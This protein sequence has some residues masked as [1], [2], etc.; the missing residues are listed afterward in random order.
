[1][2]YCANMYA[3]VVV[4]FIFLGKRCQEWISVVLCFSL[5]AF[6]FIH[7]LANFHLG[8]L[9]F[10]LLSIRKCRLK[11]CTMIWCCIV[12]SFV[13]RQS[14]SPNI[15]RCSQL[16]S[17]AILLLTL[18]FSG[19]NTHRR[20]CVRTCSLG[21][22]YVGV[23]GSAHLWKGNT[24]TSWCPP[25]KTKTNYNPSVVLQ[26]ICFVFRR[27]LICHAGLYTTIQRAPHR[28]HSHYP[29]RFYRDQWWQLHADHCPSSKH[30]LQL[31]H[32]LPWWVL[33]QQTK[34]DIFFYVKMLS[35]FF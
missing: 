30:G 1:M 9:W 23:S 13:A 4:L 16:C 17:G 5:M 28:P 12:I 35:R 10:I 7:L 21:G 25:K 14:C 34:P 18:M 20:L 33:Y 27:R 32:P 2:C 19:R 29:S 6:N 8:H 3:G 26:I 22:W 24:S 15:C 11:N 31:P